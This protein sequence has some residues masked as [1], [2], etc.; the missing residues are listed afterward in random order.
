M[1]NV[2]GKNNDTIKFVARIMV[3]VA[4]CVVIAVTF[5]AYLE[6]LWMKAEIKREAKE[7]RKLKK[8]INEIR[9]STNIPTGGV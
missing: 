7:L 4:L 8:E 2:A 3:Q 9:N 1:G 5:M 6:T